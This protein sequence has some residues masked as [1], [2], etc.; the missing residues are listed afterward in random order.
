MKKTEPSLLK[1]A[2]PLIISFWMRSLFT[3][4]DTLY[5]SFL[6]DAAIAAIGLAIPLEF[7]MIAIW[8]GLST[9]LTSYLSKAVGQK[10]ILL[11][12]QVIQAAW[13]V[14]YIIIPVFMAIGGSIYFIAPYLNLEERVIANFQ[15]YGSVLLGGSALTGFWSIIPDSI[16]KAHHDTRSTMMAGILSNVINLGL[17]TLFLF[18]FHW[19]IFGIAFSTVLGRI[20]GLLYALNRASKLENARRKKLTRLSE[21]KENLLLHPYKGIFGL[22]FP[23]SL[24]YLLMA[25]ENGLVNYLLSFMPHSTEAIA[26]YSIFYRLLMF[27]LMPMIATTV[28]VLPFVARYAAERRIET[29]RS[30]LWQVIF[31]FVLYSF[32]FVLPLLFLGGDLLLSFLSK[33]S[34]LIE[35]GGFALRTIPFFCLCLAPY[36]LCKPVFEGFQ[37]GKPTI[38]MALLR[39][40]LLAPLFAFGGM[41]LLPLFQISPFHG[42]LMGLLL[43]SLLSSI[44]YWIWCRQFLKIQHSFS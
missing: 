32:F 5:A 31:Y 7:L 14:L 37:R 23:S 33:S 1:M 25:T 21:K 4:V 26:A 16:V 24:A 11:F 39:Y 6:S 2:I 3:F 10:S 20:G 38:L 22:A 18:V 40:A 15:I 9:G 41:K 8:V 19:G 29:I 36:M 17:N 42:L 13:K 43:A 27:F 44:I 28:A 12:D 35:Y 34:Q 30:N